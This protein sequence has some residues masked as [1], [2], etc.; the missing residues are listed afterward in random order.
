MHPEAV[1]VLPYNTTNEA[2]D[3]GLKIANVATSVQSSWYSMHTPSMEIKE[4][5]K[6]IID[7][8]ASTCDA[9]RS[10]T[11]DEVTENDEEKEGSLS[12]GGG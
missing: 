5:E 8:N 2:M 6:K 3:Q 12:G 10:V 9:T 4:R 11:T 1:V 7:H